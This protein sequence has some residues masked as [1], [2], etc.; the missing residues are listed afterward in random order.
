VRDDE[1][2]RGRDGAAL[3]LG[4][5][6]GPDAEGVGEA[7]DPH[8]RASLVKTHGNLYRGARLS[9]YPIP[10]FPLE[11]GGGR[12]LLDLG[13]NWGRWT[14]AAARA[15]YRATGIDRGKKSVAAARRV[16][17][18]LGVEAEYVVGD[19]REL[20][21][22]AASFDAVFSYSVL[23]HLAKGDVPTVVAEI[24]RV[25]RPGGVAWV[26]MPNARGPLNLVRQVQRGFAPGTDQDV[27]YW[28]LS[29]LRRTFAAIGPVSITAD[30]FLTINPQ[31]ADLDLLPRRS[32]TVVRLSDTLRRVSDRMPFLVRVADSVVVHARTPS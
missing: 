20:P 4:A 10:P 19:V 23:Q 3:D 24:R 2:G 9:R 28:T 21:F 13:S 25:L 6:R 12:E 15:G 17:E 22:P 14:I 18:Q 29:E 16:A 27:R 32:R 31:V 7:V 8:V 30:G 26:E 5:R 1:A 11:P